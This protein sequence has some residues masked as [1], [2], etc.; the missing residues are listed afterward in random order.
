MND[1]GIR[2]FGWRR[3]Y[4]TLLYRDVNVTVSGSPMP[5]YCP[6][7]PP[8]E[9]AHPRMPMSDTRSYYRGASL[10]LWLLLAIE[11]KEKTDIEA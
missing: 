4:R 8:E 3:P 11:T 7:Q 1:R 9:P 10:D 2:T 6:C 5:C